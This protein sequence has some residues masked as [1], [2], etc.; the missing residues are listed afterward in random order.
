M[1]IVIFF[2]PTRDQPADVHGAEG[3]GVNQTTSPRSII[4]CEINK[5]VTDFV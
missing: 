1:N 3:D 4:F 5:I 2:M